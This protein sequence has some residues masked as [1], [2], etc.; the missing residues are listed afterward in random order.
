MLL[1][2]GIVDAEVLNSGY[3]RWVDFFVYLLF[4]SIGKCMDIWLLYILF[5]RPDR[6]GGKNNMKGVCVYTEIR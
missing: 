4:F 1:L 3:F 6:A 2:M 5:L